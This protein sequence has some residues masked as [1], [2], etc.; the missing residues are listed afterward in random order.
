MAKLRVGVLASGRGSNLQS[1]LE[2]SLGGKIDAQVV[3]VASN[4]ADAGALEKAREAG[5]PTRVIDH[6]GFASREDF[7]TAMVAAL[8]EA[9]VELVVLAGFM[10][11]LS[12]VFLEAF[13]QRIM[14]IHPSLL[15][16]FPGL[17][18][19][20]QALEYGARFSGCT[21]HFVDGGLDTGPIIIQ[22]VVPIL[23][24][25]S[26]QSLA[27]RILAEEH[28]IYPRAVQLFAEGR[29]RVEG[30]RVR[31]APKADPPETALVNPALPG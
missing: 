19:Q 31:I 8:R 24:D 21:V 28:R 11:L 30:R 23:E 7:D 20:R 10:R 29:L 16:A 15:P 14:N 4:K 12:K 26:E 13:P 27:A 2:Q 22:A 18:V 25:D 1:L 17:N 9:G 3:L 5:I 6:R